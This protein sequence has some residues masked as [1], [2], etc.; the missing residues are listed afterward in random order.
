MCRVLEHGREATTQE[1]QQ[2]EELWLPGS[3]RVTPPQAEPLTREDL[4]LAVPTNKEHLPLVKAG[5]AWRQVAFS[6][7]IM[8]GKAF[9]GAASELSQEDPSS[10]QLIS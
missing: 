7:M 2:K 10:T 3:V 9:A 4:A 1:M 6:I 8:L 5:R